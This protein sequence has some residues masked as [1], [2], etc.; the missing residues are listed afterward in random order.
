MYSVNPR[1]LFRYARSD[2][3]NSV[4]TGPKDDVDEIAKA[5]G[6]NGQTS[7]HGGYIVDCNAPVNPLVFHIDGKE[8]AVEQ[9]HLVGYTARNPSE[10]RLRMKGNSGKANTW[11]LGQPFIR[12]YCHVH[13][14][15]NNK[16]GLAKPRE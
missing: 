9:K 8:F 7:P 15:E 4:I 3:G 6:W 14:F 1:I 16:L 2:T 10:C 13:D 11:G 5:A 12:Q